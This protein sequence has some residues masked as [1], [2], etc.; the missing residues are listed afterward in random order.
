MPTQVATLS[1]GF[2]AKWALKRPHARV[3][4]KVISEIARFLEYTST[5]GISAFEVEF[6]T[7]SFWVLY[8]DRLMPI[9]WD[10]FESFVL[11]SS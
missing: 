5:V 6:Y 3:L 1:E 9:L 4:S 2:L 11:T 8:S 7:L 10:T